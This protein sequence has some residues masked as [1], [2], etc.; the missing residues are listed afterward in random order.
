MC[1]SLA[2]PSLVP[3]VLA[4]LCLTLSN[5]QGASTVLAIGDSLTS[6]FPHEGGAPFDDY[7]EYVISSRPGTT[8]VTGGNGTSD[9]GHSFVGGDGRV[10]TPGPD[11]SVW[12]GKTGLDSDFSSYSGTSSP[13]FVFVLVG[14]NNLLELGNPDDNPNPTPDDTFT[15]TNSSDYSLGGTYF[16]GD[17]NFAVPDLVTTQYDDLLTDIDAA[18]SNSAI[19]VVA[20]PPITD[21]STHIDARNSV[22]PFNTRLNTLVSGKTSAGSNTFH[23]LD[24][25]FTTSDLRADGT[26]MVNGGSGLGNEKLG[27]AIASVLPIPEPSS[28]GLL[29]LALLIGCGRRR[30][31]AGP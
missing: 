19:Y 18:L 27:N 24:P 26:H 29:A 2:H 22:G 13:D 8:F 30:R 28:T 16:N 17:T 7:Q 31:L 11:Q 10:I 4:G 21:A 6:G 3:A 15:P 5:L 1:Q 12:S 23:F 9:N 20:I 14:T 25:G